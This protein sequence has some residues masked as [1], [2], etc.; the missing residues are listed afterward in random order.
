MQRTSRT[1]RQ[2][3]ARAFRPGAMNCREPV[4]LTVRLQR[5]PPTYHRYVDPERWVRPV[6]ISRRTS[7]QP[8]GCQPVVL[9][10]HVDERPRQPVKISRRFHFTPGGDREISARRGRGLAARRGTAKRHPPGLP[11]VI[12]LRGCSSS[13]FGLA[14]LLIGLAGWL[15]CSE[16]KP[17]RDFV[18]RGWLISAARSDRASRCRAGLRLRFAGSVTAGP[19]RSPGMRCLGASARRAWPDRLF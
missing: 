8:G 7:V 13:A 2:S 17:P 18:P 19:R 12:R 1:R 10:P 9:V 14:M 5:S 11:R 6:E 15:F 4:G 16:G 3:C